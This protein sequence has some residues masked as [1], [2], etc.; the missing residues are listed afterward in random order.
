MEENE[1]K[2]ETHQAMLFVDWDLK[3]SNTLIWLHGRAWPLSGGIFV[4]ALLSVMS[5]FREEGIPI[6]VASSSALTVFPSVF[7]MTLIQVIVILVAL[8]LPIRIFFA[9]TKRDGNP[10]LPHLYEDSDAATLKIIS[11][12]MKWWLVAAFLTGLLWGLVEI[13]PKE[14]YAVGTLLMLFLVPWPLSRFITCGKLLNTGATK[15]L[16]EFQVLAYW[17]LI[18]QMLVALS[19]VTISTHLVNQWINGSKFWLVVV[20]ISAT[21]SL[22]LLQWVVAK[23]Q[24]DHRR[25]PQANRSLPLLSVTIALLI[26]MSPLGAQSAGLSLQ[27]RAPDGGACA[28]L[29]SI[30]RIK[31]AEVKSTNSSETNS[32][33]V[34]ILMEAHDTY[35]VR[36]W[37]STTKEITFIPIN[38][39]TN[40]KPC[41]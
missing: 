25:S 31:Y 29:T 40:I 2:K 38:A 18:I 15:G 16:I 24:V 12:H 30:S 11:K 35:L 27:V 6:S 22:A 23:V 37:L 17:C 4:L 33:N 7:A 21:L 20:C 8:L 5:Y 34:R 39:V 19:A 14:C 36:P 26:A 28:A 32:I 41:K 1:E 10:L 13:S 9:P 3:L